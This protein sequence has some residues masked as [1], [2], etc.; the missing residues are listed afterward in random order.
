MAALSQRHACLIM[1]PSAVVTAKPGYLPLLLSPMRHMHLLS[2]RSSIPGVAAVGA[3]KVLRSGGVNAIARRNR[4]IG[5]RQRFPSITTSWTARLS[6]VRCSAVAG[7]AGVQAGGKPVSANAADAAASKGPVSGTLTFQEAL[8]RLQEY[9]SAKGCAVVTPYN[10]E[11]GAGT[12]NPAT[13]L[14][15]LGPEP[16]NVAYIEPSVRPD[17]SRYGDNPNRVQQHTQFQVILKPDPQNAQELYLGSLAALGIDLHAHDIRFVEDNW[18]SPVLGAWGLGWEVWMDGMEITQFTYFQQ[19]GSIACSPV[20][21][22]ITYGMERIMMSLQ[23]VDHFKKIRYTPTISYGELFLE[24]EREMSAYNL[25]RADVARTRARFDLYDQEASSMLALGLVIPAYNH[26]LKSSHAF[27]V[28][29]ARGA[30][31]VTERARFFGRM[32][33][34]ARQCAQ[35]WIKTREELGHPLGV[36]APPPLPPPPHEDAMGTP[37]ARGQARMFVLEIGSE[38]LPPQDVEAGLAQLHEKTAA[39]LK[40]LRLEHGAISVQGTPRRLTVMVDALAAWQSES[41]ERVRG[42]PCKTAYDKDGKPTKALEGFLRKNGASLDA[43]DKEADAKGTEYVFATIQLPGRPAHEVLAKELQAMIASITF[44]KSMRWTTEAT[45]SRPLRWLLALHGEAIVSFNH[46]GAQSNRTSRVLRNAAAPVISVPSAEEYSAAIAKAGLLLDVQQRRDLIWA[47]ACKLAASAGG[48]VPPS[49]QE[50]LLQEVAN[51]VEAPWPL[52]GRFDEKF[53]KLPREVLVTVMRKHQR[54]FPVEDASSG[55]LL[56]LFITVANGQFQPDDALVRKGNEAV[57]RARYEDAQF[58][59]DADLSKPLVEFRPLLSGITFQEKLGSML[60]KSRRV[61]ACIEPL[62]SL[63]RTPAQDLGV[64]KEAAVMATA[65]LATSMVVEFTGLA[66]VMGR[67]YA[68]KGGASP[69]VAEAVFESCLPRQANDQL[70]ATPAGSLLA[71][72][73][74]LDSLVGLFAVGC[75]PTAN[76]D[77]FGLR[78][79]AYGLVQTLVANDLDLDLRQAFAVS[80]QKQPIPVKEE[81]L[82]EVLVFVTR[83]LEQLLTD[84]GV[85]VHAVRA[86]L[87]ERGANPALALRSAKQL[88]SVMGGDALAGVLESY[89]RPSRIVKG[90]A[91][92]TNWQIDESLFEGTE[93]KQLW[94]VYRQ[95]AAQV[96]PGMNV[97]DFVRVSAALRGPVDAFFNNVF[98]MAEDEKLRKNRLRLLWDIASLANGI[99]DLSAL[100]GY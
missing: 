47:G 42:P 32:R 2:C 27:N 73:D 94:A 1:S 12:M 70:P 98:V 30:V 37:P 35:Q 29:D 76:A 77:P 3:A 97:D 14:R 54:Y 31:G 68:L 34:L 82:K 67:H 91:I 64:A 63:L 57:L 88:S 55:N 69:A 21:V 78:R 84:S 93:E 4:F 62:A 95:V 41:A 22:E 13:Y 89:S 83:R 79:S 52:L 18:E 50:G 51:L 100:P 48:R 25:E 75:E 11:V 20:S 74:R 23:G 33:A 90:K 44:P 53:L 65:D 19:A 60:D 58:F 80:A 43:L 49:S 15:V 72:A 71:I 26:L 96:S 8:Q 9:W 38:E 39:L 24:N 36:S 45:Y 10:T 56:P 85:D 59:Y 5:E 87:A 7:Q 16:W 40:Q 66:G 28:L 17:D 92:D 61:E 99:V 81:T 46:A 86:V 6:T